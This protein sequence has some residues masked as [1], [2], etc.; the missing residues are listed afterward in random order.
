MKQIKILLTMLLALL[1]VGLMADELSI[2]VSPV[3]AGE[4]EVAISLDNS[5]QY[6]AFQMDVVLPDGVT[7]TDGAIQAED[8]LS[9]F[10]LQATNHPHGYVR[11]T[12]HHAK[13]QDIPGT[14]GVLFTLRVQAEKLY[15][16]QIRLHN[17]LFTT[18]SMDEVTLYDVN[19]DT[20]W[21][22]ITLLQS[23]RKSV[24]Y[25]L[26]G[27]Q[28]NGRIVIKNGKKYLAK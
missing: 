11:V 3:A 18:S 27:R 2:S 9:G 28:G 26:M 24:G 5:E 4:Y 10:S 14:Q 19:A 20:P 23:Q 17:C 13:N 21:D 16:G 12:A 22:G 7:F 8:R 25:N 6:R 15:A 1:P